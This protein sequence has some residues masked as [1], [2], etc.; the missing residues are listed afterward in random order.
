VE[1]LVSL[2]LVMFSAEAQSRA[3]VNSMY[4]WFGNKCSTPTFH[5]SSWLSRGSDISVMSKSSL[6]FPVIKV[7]SLHLLH[8]NRFD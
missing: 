5:A 8:I 4:R 2:R 3:I 7:G 6:L 1:Q